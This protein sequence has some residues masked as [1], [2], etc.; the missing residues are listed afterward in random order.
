MPTK[1]TPRPRVLVTGADGMIGRA[2]TTRLHANGYDVSAL[3]LSWSAPLAAADR[4]FTGDASD[5]ALVT[6]AMADVSAVVHMAAI[7]HPDLGT[8]RA[9]FVGNTSATFTV[10]NAAGEHGI[11]R[12][13]LASSINAFGVPMNRHDVYPAYYPLDEASP[14]AHDDAYSLSKWVDEQS[15]AWAGSRFG[16]TVVAL[17]FPLVRP[18]DE[19]RQHARALQ[20]LPEERRRL[21]REGWAYLELDDAVDAIL[22]ALKAELSGV[23]TMI[24]A[25][26]DILLDEPT[27]T[28]LDRYAN[29]SERRAR[30]EGYRAPVDT[31]AAR[32]LLGWTPQHSIHTPDPIR[33]PLEEASA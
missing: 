10:L 29:R 31:S 3:S 28:L 22:L 32:A 6:D 1:A 8:A 27:E 26:D 12:V 20:G 4:V 18:L 25:A 9:I 5:E 21:A 30:F 14:V 19:L 16:M 13:V 23:H 24:V 33:T 17:R 11:E 15:A 2:A 7:P